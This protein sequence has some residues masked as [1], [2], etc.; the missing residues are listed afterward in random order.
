MAE[1]RRGFHGLKPASL[2]PSDVPKCLG[3][4]RRREISRLREIAIGNGESR[5][6]RSRVVNIG[7]RTLVQPVT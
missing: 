4:Q 6:L 3:D 5:F 2:R 7:A 1:T